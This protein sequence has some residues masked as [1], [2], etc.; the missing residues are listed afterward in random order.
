MEE[1]R[2]RT[3]QR[4][5]AVG[6]QD[7][8]ATEAPPATLRVTVNLSSRA[9]TALHAITGLTGD[10]KT[11]AINKALQAY[12]LIQEAQ[13]AGGGA[14]LQDNGNARPSQIRFY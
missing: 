3:D 12:A 11:E 5:D 9:T 10:S 14:W 4:S 2:M 1:M 7:S 6:N 13:H 8:S